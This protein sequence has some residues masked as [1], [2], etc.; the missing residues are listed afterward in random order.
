MGPLVEMVRIELTFQ[1]FLFRLSRWAAPCHPLIGGHVQ[2]RTEISALQ[3]RRST[4]KL[5]AHV[6]HPEG[7]EPSYKGLEHPVNTPD[8]GAYW[9]E[10]SDS[11]AE[12]LLGRK[13]VCQLSLH[14]RVGSP[15]TN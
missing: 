8:V 2:N 6:V 4:I 3:V 13:T 7:I 11:N 12:N 1:R 9:C 14:S 5:T 10:Y 15:T